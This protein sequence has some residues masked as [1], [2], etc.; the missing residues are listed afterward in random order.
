MRNPAIL[1]PLF[2]L[3]AWSFLVLLHSLIHPSDNDVLHRLAAFTLANV[4]LALL[5]L[6]AGF[7][8]VEASP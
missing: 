4:P 5:R 8:L 2:A 7:H 6:A 1:H 3:A